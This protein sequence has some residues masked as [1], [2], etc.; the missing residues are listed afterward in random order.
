M[1]VNFFVSGSGGNFK[2]PS[3]SVPGAQDS[4]RAPFTS[5]GLNRDEA[6]CI[7]I[8]K[9]GTAKYVQYGN[10]NVVV[11]FR[12]CFYVES[13]LDGLGY[14][15]K[16]AIDLYRRDH[17]NPNINILGHSNGG[18]AIARY[19]QA[20]RP[21]FIMNVI[22]CATPYNGVALTVK[23][24]GFVKEV[25]NIDLSWSPQGNINMFVGEDNSGAN[26]SPAVA[27]DGTISTDSGLCGQDVY[28]RAVQ[29]VQAADHGTILTS[30][31]VMNVLNSWFN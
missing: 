15:L 11:T 2:D 3:S 30:Q 23:P 8:S 16:N 6:T 18:N 17:G 24:T 19:V 20:F 4:F 28:N 10:S 21:S 5:W 1:T 12:S 25:E 29:I 14:A 9:N 7:E 31:P 27:N 26:F 22:T 13:E